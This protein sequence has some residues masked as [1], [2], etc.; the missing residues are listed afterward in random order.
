MNYLK[1]AVLNIDNYEAD[2]AECIKYRSG[3][4]SVAFDELDGI[5]NKSAFTRD[6]MHKSQGWFS[7]RLHGAHV[8]CTDVQFKPDEARLIAASFRDIARRLEGLASEI[9][10]VAD[11]D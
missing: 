2:R 6:Y 4:I 8:C 7:Q 10:A 5:I 11:I 1:K 9:E 3:A